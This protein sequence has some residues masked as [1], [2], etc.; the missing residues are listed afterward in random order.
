MSVADRIASYHEVQP[1]GCWR[2]TAYV[3]TRGYGQL[4]V[5]GKKREA[6]RVSYETFVGPVPPGLHLD[7]LCRNRAC[8]N[9]QHLEP[10]TQRENSL[11]G[12]GACATHARKAHCKNGHTF[13]VNSWEP[14]RRRCNTCQNASIARYRARKSALIVEKEGAA[15]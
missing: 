12:Y 5:G 10:V 15:A 6:Y 13:S 4:L 3:N 11:R 1:D 7:H 2:W 8:V 9:P 14:G